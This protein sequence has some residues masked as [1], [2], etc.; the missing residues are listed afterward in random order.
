MGIVASRLDVPQAPTGNGKLEIGALSKF[1]SHSE[2]LK[3]RD[4]LD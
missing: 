3:W 2:L 4:P 1:A